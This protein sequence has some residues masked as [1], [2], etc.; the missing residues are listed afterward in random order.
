[1]KLAGL[2]VFTFLSLGTYQLTDI[3]PE[4]GSKLPAYLVPQEN[5]EFYMTHPSQ[6]R[7]QG[8]DYRICKRRQLTNPCRRD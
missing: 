7:F 1:M 3:V 6:L 8:H 2:L 5:R 4:I